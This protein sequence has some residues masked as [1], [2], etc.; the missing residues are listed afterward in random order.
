MY[1]H[2]TELYSKEELHG[3]PDSRYANTKTTKTTKASK[4]E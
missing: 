3:L 2:S 4:M 1:K